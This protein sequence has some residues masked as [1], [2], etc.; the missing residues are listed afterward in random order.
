MYS[1]ENTCGT[2]HA[3]CDPLEPEPEP[4][5]DIRVQTHLEEEVESKQGAAG[6]DG[7]PGGVPAGDGLRSVGRVLGGDTRTRRGR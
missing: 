6:D 7:E 3:Q 5:K 4:A 2:E 1:W